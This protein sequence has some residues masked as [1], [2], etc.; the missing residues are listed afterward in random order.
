MTHIMHTLLQC[1]YILNGQWL[2]WIKHNNIIPERIYDTV[3]SLCVGLIFAIFAHCRLWEFKVVRSFNL[4]SYTTTCK[5]KNANNKKLR[6]RKSQKYNITKFRKSLTLHIV[7]GSP[8]T[9][10]RRIYLPGCG[11]FQVVYPRW[12]WRSRGSRF[13]SPWELR[14]W[15]SH[16]IACQSQHPM[17]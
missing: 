12:T 7:V 13:R 9:K 3:T 17:P 1:I 4:K 15:H 6:P 5:S 16:S 2:A 11:R 8:L 10:T 14:R